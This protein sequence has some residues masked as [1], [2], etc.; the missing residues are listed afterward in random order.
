MCVLSWC[1]ACATPLVVREVTRDGHVFVIVQN[2]KSTTTK[3]CVECIDD[4]VWEEGPSHRQSIDLQISL[5]F[6]FNLLTLSLGVQQ[7]AQHSLNLVAE[8]L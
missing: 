7:I 4:T 8:L 1:G 3:N 5:G 6:V 2:K